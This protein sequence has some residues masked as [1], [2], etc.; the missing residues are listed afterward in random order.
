MG[1]KVKLMWTVKKNA[2]RAFIRKKQLELAKE[3]SELNK[4][5]GVSAF[6][7]MYGPGESEPV[8]WPSRPKI[9]KLLQR[10]QSFPKEERYKL[11]TTPE[12]YLREERAMRQGLIG[13][14]SNTK[15]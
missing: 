6:V 14:H 12:S 3:V 15:N 8:I 7:I 2:R 1:K 5:C 10:F 11:M 13:G 4:V 9:E